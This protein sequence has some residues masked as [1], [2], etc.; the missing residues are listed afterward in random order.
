MNW[1]TVTVSL[2]IQYTGRLAGL[3]ISLLSVGILTRHLGINRY[4]EYSVALAIASLIITFSDFGFFWSTIHNFLNQDNQIEAIRDILGIRFLLTFLL[5]CISL[6]V[7]WLGHFSPGVKQAYTILSIFIFASSLNNILAA[8]YQAEYKLLLPTLVD[9]IA[10]GTNLLIITVGHFL[11]QGLTWFIV[12]VSFTAFLNMAINWVV[13]H[14]RLGPI[15]PRLFG[16]PWRKYYNSVFLVGLM[17]L[18]SALYYK[19]DIVILSWFKDAATTPDVG[20]YSAAQKVIELV[21]IFQGLFLASIFPLMVREIKTDLAKFQ[22]TA[23][24]TILILM[25]AGA[26]IAVFGFFLSTAIIGLIGGKQFMVA[27]SLTYAGYPITAATCLMVLLFF[28]LFS[29][30][31]GT[32]TISILASGEVKQLVKVNVA[33]TILNIVLNLWLIPRYSYLAA[34]FTTLL[35]EILILVSNGLFFYYHFSFRPPFLQLAK[36]LLA[37]LPGAIFLIITP[38]WALPFRAVIA[39]LLYLSCLAVL[40]PNSRLMVKELLANRIR[41]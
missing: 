18:F 7:V 26:P 27:S 13:L 39:T 31:S 32:F 38:G 25:A 40:I 34:S 3:A 14:D 6:V 35:T 15:W 11:H 37:T 5:I 8:V 36:I 2:G 28:V 21:M 16:L 10:R 20:I 1:K 4:G 12:G 19:I 9:L 24:R 41:A 22:Q 33:A 30:I 17:T 23:N 29:Y